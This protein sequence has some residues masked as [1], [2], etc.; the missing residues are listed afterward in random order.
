[1]KNIFFVLLAFVVVVFSSCK[2][3]VVEKE[4]VSTYPKGEPMIENI[5]KWVGNDRVLIREIH[6]YSNGVKEIEGEYNENAK[7]HGKWTYWH[8]GGQIWIEENYKDGVKNGTYTEWYKSGKKNFQGKYK[9]G[10]ASG[11]WT[12][13]D[14]HGKKIYSKNYKDGKPID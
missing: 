2:S 11:K 1:M 4:V 3:E 9:N 10:L 14:E 7:K 12:F 8:E 6:Y 5:Y 13:W